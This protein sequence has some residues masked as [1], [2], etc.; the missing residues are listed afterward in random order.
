MKKS[1]FLVTI[2]LLAL[3]LFTAFA[4]PKLEVVGGTKIEFGD[5]ERGAIAERKVTLK[6]TGNQTLVIN[7]VQ[8]SCG[9]TGT[10]V[11]KE[12]IPPG[13]TGEVKITFN[14]STFSGPVH[15]TVTVI[16]NSPGNDREVIEFSAKVTQEVSV[17]PAQ[18]WFRDA[19]LGKTTTISLTVKNDGKE[20]L[21]ITGFRSTIEGVILSLPAKQ[22]QPGTSMEIEGIF[23]PTTI[24]QVISDNLI[25]KTTSKK[26]P[27]VTVPLFGSVKEFKF[28]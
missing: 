19:E 21:G 9:C 25:L 22:I 26:Q 4:Q 7:K 1:V 10:L 3:P 11:S 20:P 23:K 27:E 24:K 13:K 18:I 16:S 28:Q 2:A 12:E 6:N 17:T 5:I 14:S 8:A 15:K